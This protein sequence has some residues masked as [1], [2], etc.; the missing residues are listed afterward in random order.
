MRAELLSTPSTA[1]LKSASAGL[2]QA[3]NVIRALF[4]PP[5][6][7]AFTVRY[8]DGSE[9]APGIQSDT[10][11]T[12]W[13]RRPGALRRMLLPPSELAIAEAFIDGDVDLEGDAEFAMNLGNIIGD[14]VQ[15]AAGFA[16]LLPMLMTLPKDDA[17]DQLRELRRERFPRGINSVARRK[18][19]ADAIQHHYDVGNDFYRLWLD[20]RMVYTCAFFETQNDSLESAQQAKLDLVCR[21]LQLAPGMRLLDIG[22]GWG[23][24]IM[25]AS[26]HYGVDATGITLSDAQAGLGRERIDAAGLSDRCRIEIRDYRDLAAESAYDRVASVGMMEHVG[27]DRLG[28]YFE[29]AYRTLKPG[30][31]FLN[32]TIVRD[33]HRT[34]ETPVQKLLNRLWKRDQFIHR[35]VFPDGQ[36]VPV[37][38]MVK[39]AEHAGF[40]LRDIENLREHYAMTLRH[41]RRRLESHDEEAIAIA[42]ERKFRTWRLYLMAAANG[43]RVGN[44]A[45]VQALL[46]KCDDSGNSGMPLTRYYMLDTTAA[47]A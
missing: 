42:G 17:A 37:A 29:C 8:W 18:G 19:G 7:R 15:S 20:E 33:G 13:F 24:L 4:G 44:T 39:C 12:L 27:F 46:A 35:Y 21:K 6:E 23:A 16:A 2:I 41:W 3:R 9:E 45:I 1:T 22:C 40:E 28:G 11:F 32:H 34:E 25:H 30:G 31:L 36:L 38:H 10:P 43:F 5:P 14:R 47:R 26:A